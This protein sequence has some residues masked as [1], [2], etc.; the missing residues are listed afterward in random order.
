LD[1]GKA[2][3]GKQGRKRPDF[4]RLGLFTEVERSGGLGAM[5]GLKG[6]VEVIHQRAGMKGLGGVGDAKREKT[7]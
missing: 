1:I 3:A 4:M 7:D 2:R 6:Q 5:A